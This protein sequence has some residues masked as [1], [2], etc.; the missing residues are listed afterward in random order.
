VGCN[1]GMIVNSHATADVDG[2]ADA[3]GLVGTN[4]APSD[5]GTRDG[6][7]FDSYALGSVL[8]NKSS[9][10]LAGQSFGS[11][12]IVTSYFLY[13]VNDPTQISKNNGLGS[14]L[15]ERQ[16]K[17]R[18]SYHDWDFPGVEADTTTHTWAMPEGGY[19]QLTWQAQA[20]PV[21]YVYRLPEGRATRL[22]EKAGFIVELAEP[23]YHQTVPAGSVI[24]V[25]AP[26]I[27]S[28]GQT[29][30]L[31]LSR[32]IYNWQDNPGDG[33]FGNP[34]RIATPGQLEA[35]GYDPGRQSAR[36]LLVSDIDL[37]ERVYAGPLIPEF[38]GSFDG[39][40]HEIRNLCIEKDAGNSHAG[41]FGVL[42]GT[43]TAVKL[44]NARLIGTRSDGYSYVG[45]MA[46]TNKGAITSC[47]ITARAYGV[48]R[49]G[50]VVSD[51]EGEID[52]CS[53]TAHVKGTNYV[54]GVVG[55]NTGGIVGEKEYGTR[56][57]LTNCHVTAQVYGATK[58]GGMIGSNWGHVSNCHGKGD[59]GG[60]WAVG[61]IV[62]YNSYEFFGQ[63]K[64]RAGSLDRSSFEG[65][66]AATIPS[67]AAK[68][69]TT[70]TGPVGGLVGE[71]H[72]RITK[73]CTR[74]QVEG[75]QRIGGLA[76]SN[77]EHSRS[78]QKVTIGGGKG[79][80]ETTIEGGNIANC[81]SRC[82]VV[83]EE[84]VGGLLGGNGFASGSGWSSAG[85]ITNC[86]AGGRVTTAGPATF[87]AATST[88]GGL[89][90]SSPTNKVT[91]CYFLME[92]DSGG[93][94]D[95]GIGVAR[96]DSG[97]KNQG[98]FLKWAF[99]SPGAVWFMPENDYPRLLWEQVFVPR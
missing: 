85:P 16:M 67:A 20:V 54:G 68:G 96:T 12:S 62:G 10:G 36:F 13:D 38:W 64:W 34:Y 30:H 77:T 75:D 49:I 83:G 99:S 5:T 84:N 29:L 89:I 14:P 46:K 48:S 65:T 82:E 86:Y 80:I 93:G 95:N 56:G 71:N 11:S 61:G 94:P 76:G 72:G 9:G 98:T 79:V 2:G 18:K 31:V 25:R 60:S 58:V 87:H 24:C 73:C 63:D 52:G 7:V 59:V 74:G 35:I 40:D 42:S 55:T 19:P 47:T 44:I 66:V 81:Y 1:R 51:N 50:A 27:V 32:G 90:G 53:V 43:L 57:A 88:V 15:P 39:N 33:S 97:L 3:G 23:D 37:R 78:V 70:P 41:L 28:P 17:E 22:L 21:P 4:G 45:A 91:G 6:W 26:T 69:A 8:G 92:G